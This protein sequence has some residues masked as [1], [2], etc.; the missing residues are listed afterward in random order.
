M[1]RAARIALCAAV[2]AAP[3]WAC[4]TDTALAAPP[5]AAAP[6]AKL[7]AK[8]LETALGAEAEAAVVEALGTLKQAG[9]A[10]AP[11]APAVE[12]LLERGTTVNI[13]KAAMDA[14]GAIGKPSSSAALRPYVRHR[15]P[16]L[17]RAAV[18]NLAKTKGP[19]A[20]TA[21]REGLRSE[22]GMVRG[23]SAAGLGALGAKEATAELFLALDRGVVEAAGAAGQLCA[24]ADCQKLTRYLGK[25]PFE[26][27]TSGLDAILF[28]AP[29]LDEALLLEVVTAV[30]ELATP[31]AGKYLADVAARWPA[32]GSAKVKNALE[33]AVA[34]IPGSRGG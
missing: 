15:T 6:A 17:R 9:A 27:M 28:R 3:L 25:L 22:D 33:Q 31:E 20:I 10:G 4:A 8:A 12:R 16:E 32:T 1:P 19:E 30:R 11:L 5:A 29:P 2:A 7:D 34:M 13:G 14:L 24:G 21:F 23:F 26:V 18:R